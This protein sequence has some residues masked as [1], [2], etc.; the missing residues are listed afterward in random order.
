MYQ[1][2][3]STLSRRSWGVVGWFAALILTTPL[4]G[5]PPME[6]M[7]PESV[8][9][10]RDSRADENILPGKSTAELWR[11]GGHV[12]GKV[13]TP[14]THQRRLAEA[15]SIQARQ[16]EAERFLLSGAAAG[17]A[18][19]SP[20]VRVPDLAGDRAS[21]PRKF[22]IKRAAPPLP[23]IKTVGAASPRL[24]PGKS[25]SD[26]KSAFLGGDFELKSGA[27]IDID[28]GSYSNTIELADADATALSQVNDLTPFFEIH[29]RLLE[30]F[31][32]HPVF[33]FTDVHGNAVAAQSRDLSGSHSVVMTRVQLTKTQE[34]I[35]VF[36]LGDFGLTGHLHGKSFVVAK[37]NGSQVESDMAEYLG[38]APGARAYIYG[39]DARWVN[40]TRVVEGNHRELVRRAGGPPHDLPSVE[41]RLRTLQARSD[42]QP[43]TVVNGLP[44]DE[45]EVQDM[46]AYAGDPRLWQEFHE[47]VDRATA[48]TDAKR[49][50]SAREWLQQLQ[51]GNSDMVILVAHATGADLYL[52]GKPISFDELRALPSRAAGTH[53]PRMAVLIA[54]NAGRPQTQEPAAWWSLFKRRTVVPLAQLLVEKGY[55][56]KVV[57]PAQSIQPQESMEVLRHALEGST[58]F[59]QFDGW[60]N[61]A[62]LWSGVLGSVG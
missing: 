23:P 35:T 24:N 34:M 20:G 25:L 39:G 31:P 22:V 33:H 57:G 32:R 54:C 48:K 5:A 30:D 12:L 53:R 62:V 56:D 14:E 59:S 42:H 52:G 8:E 2:G 1:P 16:V 38:E 40:L 49:A 15:L 43:L 50:D 27:P 51:E 28:S 26:T 6:V 17:W 11:N 9:P 18:Y 55:F 3:P 44:R 61:W 45:K 41:G 4:E 21:E 7:R 37:E 46:G 10:R 47:Q 13:D 60:T 19:E 36:R 58:D 29:N